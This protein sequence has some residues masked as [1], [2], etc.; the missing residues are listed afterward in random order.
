ME[1]RI[2][3][4]SP[5]ESKAPT[6]V[7]LGAW[8]RLGADA[9]LGETAKPRSLKTAPSGGVA[10]CAPRSNAGAHLTRVP[11]EQPALAISLFGRHAAR[12][13]TLALSPPAHAYGNDR[14]DGD[15]RGTPQTDRPVD[16]L[17]YR[18]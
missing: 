2:R 1:L 3:R 14:T 13:P 6:G 15:A 16:R 17:P 5:S 11:R 4:V 18:S 9:A 7:P 12:P 8:A 10:T